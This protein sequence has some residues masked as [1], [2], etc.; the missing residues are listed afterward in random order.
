M[1][2]TNEKKEIHV[3]LI[4]LGCPKNLVDSEAMLGL[5]KEEGYTI[6]TD[7]NRSDVIIINT[8]G[9]INNAKKESI[10]TI[11]SAAENKAGNCKYLIVAGCLSERF[12][13]E[14]PETLPEVDAVLGVGEYHKIAEVTNNLLEFGRPPDGIG[15]RVQTY[16]DELRLKHLDAKRVVSTGSGYTYLKIAEGCNNRCAFCVIPILRGPYLSRT[17]SDIVSEA[18]SLTQER[19]MELILVA[20]DTTC[21]GSD[22]GDGSDL[23][24]LMDE[25]AEI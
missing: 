13:D 7:A 25:L 11:L 14:F 10:E 12:S 21:Y 1:T 15:S 18:K 3:C 16:S 24:R 5:L 20:Q 22:L 8:C 19:E 17:V 4:S 9:F 23:Y 6:T 2:K